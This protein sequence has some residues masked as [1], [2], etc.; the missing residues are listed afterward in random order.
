M[1]QILIVYF[2]SYINKISGRRTFFE[3]S[4]KID[5]GFM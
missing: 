5:Y 1:L 4:D 2:M 3:K